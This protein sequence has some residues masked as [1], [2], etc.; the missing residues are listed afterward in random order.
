M[1]IALKLVVHPLLMWLLATLVLHLP[2]VTTTVMTVV[3]ALP[4]A[5][6]AF[7]FVERNGGNV[8]RVASTILLST[9]LS[10]VT[11]TLLIGWLR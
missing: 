8:D 6:T 2:A 1:L 4:A 5:G 7:L 10:F 11:I 9:A 3:A